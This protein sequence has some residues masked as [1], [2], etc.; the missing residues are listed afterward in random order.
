MRCP[1][2]KQ[3]LVDRAPVGI[4]SFGMFIGKPEERCPNCYRTYK[5][6]KVLWRNHTIAQKVFRYLQVALSIIAS[7][8]L[9]LFISGLTLL[10]L[11]SV[12]EWNLIDLKFPERLTDYWYINVVLVSFAL[13]IPGYVSYTIISDF[14]ELI[15]I[16]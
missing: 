15:K 7:S 6:E 4:N 9:Y 2:C 8:A 5:S 10:I 3:V 14:K 12:F 13:F 16:T 11:D 1:Y